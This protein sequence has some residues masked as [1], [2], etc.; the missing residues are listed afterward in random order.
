M[1]IL[2]G[3]AR[4]SDAGTYGGNPKLRPLS[5]CP[6]SGYEQGYHTGSGWGAG[7]KP[8]VATSATGPDTRGQRWHEL[9]GVDR[10]G[11]KTCWSVLSVAGAGAEV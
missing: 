10:D 3:A 8:S 11:P 2:K 6:D 7:S 9:P 1:V 4:S 5:W